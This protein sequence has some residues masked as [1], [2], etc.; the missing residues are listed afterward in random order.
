M[1]SNAVA[2]SVECGATR[3]PSSIPPQVAKRSHSGAGLPELHLSEYVRACSDLPFSS[4]GSSNCES[5]AKP[6][7]LIF[8]QT[9]F[10][11]RFELRRWNRFTDCRCLRIKRAQM[12]TDKATQADASK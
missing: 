6:G 8:V 3:P 2:E 11:L 12:H 9:L 10:E 4:P 5:P 7:D 1:A